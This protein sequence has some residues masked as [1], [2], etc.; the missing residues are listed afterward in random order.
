MLNQRDAIEAEHR[1]IEARLAAKYGPP[2]AMP[3]R[4]VLRSNLDD[5]PSDTVPKLPRTAKTL[6]EAAQQNGWEHRVGWSLVVV[7]A[8]YRES[9]HHKVIE[10]AYV[11]TLCGVWLR[12]WQTRA[13]A[14]FGL[15]GEG[16]PAAETGTRGA[17]LSVPGRT[18][19]IGVTALV[20]YIRGEADLNEAA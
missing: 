3:Q 8:G 16:V 15:P 17:E 14:M 11:M 13:W 5:W 1:R 10:Q 7:P 12:A 9:N 18:K 19:A 6:C 20:A 2:P 4:V